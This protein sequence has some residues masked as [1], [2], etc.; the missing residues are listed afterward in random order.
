MTSALEVIASGGLAQVAVASLRVLEWIAIAVGTALTVRRALRSLLRRRRAV[1]TP[2]EPNPVAEFW[3]RPGCP[4]CD[5]RDCLDR[6][7]CSCS[8][9]CGSWLREAK[10]EAR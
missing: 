3:E 5:T 1:R 7:L 10:E 8:Q 2:T 4:W 6:T 9:A